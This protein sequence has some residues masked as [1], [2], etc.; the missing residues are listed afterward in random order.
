MNKIRSFARSTFVLLFAVS[1][2]AI[3]AFAQSTRGILAGTVTDS[4]G[5]VI[6]GAT[7]VAINQA[8]S[9]KN[10]AISTSSGS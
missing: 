10:E 4:S 2:L 9:G 8:T 1:A 7:V 6:P 3:P 5:A